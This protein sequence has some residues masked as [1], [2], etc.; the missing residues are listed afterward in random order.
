MLRA[1]AD[2]QHDKGA[3]HALASS[4]VTGH[5][6]QRPLSPW[7]SGSLPIAIPPS[8]PL[9][10][11]RCCSRGSPMSLEIDG[12][13]SFSLCSISTTTFSVI[14]KNMSMTDIQNLK[15]SARWR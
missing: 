10:P 12:G 15:S 6:E 14:T 8:A 4:D 9:R 2:I 11:Q 13:S 1:L 3:A 5:L 7:E